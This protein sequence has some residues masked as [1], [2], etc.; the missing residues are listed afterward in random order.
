MKKLVLLFVAAVSIVSMAKAQQNLVLYH[1][2]FVPQHQ[3]VNPASRPFAK[4]NIGL[5]ALSSIYFRHENTIFNPYHMLSN[6]GSYAA[7]RVDNFKSQVRDL[8][9]LGIDGAIDLLNVGF[10]VGEKHY[11][12]VAARERFQVRWTMPGDMLLF[13]FT[14][15]ASFDELEDGTIDFS[16]FRYHLNHFRELSL[17]WQFEMNEK[18]SFGARIKRLYGYENIDTKNSSVQWRTDPETFDW[19]ISGELD[20]YSSG[21]YQQIDSLDDNSDIENGDVLDYFLRRENGGWGVDLGA[22][23]RVN[24]KL[25]VSASIVDLG[26]I[27]WRSYTRNA[28]T[29]AGDFT[30]TGLD[31]SEEILASDSS[32]NDNVDD[33]IDDLI[34]DLEE[35]FSFSDN[36]DSYR[37]ALMARVHLGAQYKLYETDN[38]AGTAGLLLQTEIYK[39][40]LRPT[41]TASYQQRVGRWLTAHLAYSV[42]DRNFR[43]LG[44]GLSLNGGP[45]QFYIATDNLL[46]GVADRLIIEE[47]GVSNTEIPYPSFARTMQVHTGLNLTFGRKEKDSDGDGVVDKKDECPETPGLAAFNGCPDTDGDGIQ[48]KLDACPTVA[49]PKDLLG[50]PDDDGDGIIN[51]EDECPDTPGS[52]DFAGCP[53]TD[54]DGIEDREDDCP[55]KA[56]T[57]KFGG[58]PD[59]DNDGLRDIDDNCPNKSGPAENNGCPWED[60]DGDGVLD[61]DDRCPQEAGPAENGGCPY[62]D[63]DGDGILDKD[64][65]CPLTPGPAEN[66]GCPVLEKEEQ[67]VIDTAF[68]NLEFVSGKDVIKDESKASLTKLAELLIEKEDWK[69]QIAGHTDNVGNDNTNMEL[70]KDRANAVADYIESRG[71]SRDRMIIQ[72]FGETQP[73]AD[74]ETAEGRQKNRRVEMEIKFD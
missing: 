53:D 43:N 13:P 10:A 34:D 56:G 9:S 37:S 6:E 44:A 7:L 68:D 73:I 38:T 5:P 58:C 59:T 25:S 8:N 1:M 2:D 33:V 29:S 47:D 57:E 71:V 36:T 42:I 63:K 62:L 19:T 32:F 49:G 23:Y 55:E 15:N 17:G 48:D 51:K 27:T 45:I 41:I 12:S 30:F 65:E 21:V 11:F 54:G 35:N 26:F 14:G 60:V 67:E 66:N 39:G 52:V 69:I 74:N 28:L 18:W 20:V 3:Y 31:I 16:G 24:D 50:C 70:S 4:V 64:D 46:A 61:K 22:E 72:W 40:Q